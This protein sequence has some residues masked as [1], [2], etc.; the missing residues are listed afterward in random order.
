MVLFPCWLSPSLPLLELEAV[1]TAVVEAAVVEVA[2]VVESHTIVER[3]YSLI[4]GLIVKAKRNLPTSTVSMGEVPAA[5]PALILG[6]MVHTS[7]FG[8]ALM[9][10]SCW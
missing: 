5:F 6:R 10:K 9:V 4:L 7:I 3:D 1:V 2:V 8:G